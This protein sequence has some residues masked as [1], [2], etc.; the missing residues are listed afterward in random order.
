MRKTANRTW[1]FTLMVLL[2]LLLV[3]C[4]PGGLFSGNMLYAPNR[5]IEADADTLTSALNALSEGD[6]AGVITLTEAEFTSLLRLALLNTKQDDSL[7][8]DV[9]A[10][11]EPDTIFLKT[12]LREGS[13]PFIPTEAAISVEGGL[14]SI[15]NRLVFNLNRA[16]FGVIPILQPALQTQLENEVSQSVFSVFDRV[17]PLTV[18]VGS[19]EITIELP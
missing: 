3:A 14:Q 7:I 12:T 11:F 4:S 13:L 15:D 5:I 9:K 18:R 17:S 16:S 10:W 8:T 2:V 19:G 6:R 1:R